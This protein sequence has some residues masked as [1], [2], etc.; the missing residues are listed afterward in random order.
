M[1]SDSKRE[2]DRNG[3]RPKQAAEQPGLALVRHELRVPIDHILSYCESLQEDVSTPGACRDELRRIHAAARRLLGLIAEHFDEES[4]ALQKPDF[5]QIGHDLR[6]PVNHIV[7]YAEMLVEEAEN[8]G[9]PGVVPNLRRIA[10][11]ARQWL[12]LMERHLLSLKDQCR[13][14]REGEQGTTEDSSAGA[15]GF[16][17]PSEKRLTGRVLV[18]DDDPANRQMLAR[19][20]R[21]QGLTVSVA[22]SGEA[23]LEKARQS[24]YDLILLDM[25]MP[26]MDGDEVLARLKSDPALAPIPVIMISALDQ[27]DRIA[28]CV[29]MGAEDYIAKPFN[30]VFLRARIKACLEQKRLREQETSF[31]RRI[32]EEK[33]KTDELLHVILPHEVAEELRSTS[34]VRPKRFSKVAVLF[35][36]IVGFAAYSCGKTPEEIVVHLQTLVESFENIAER[37]GLEKIKTIGDCFMAVAGLCS[38]SSNPAIDAVRCGLEMIGA[39]RAHP[40]GWQVRV[41]VNVGPVVAGVVGRKK[42]QYDVWGDTVNLAARLEQAGE[43]GAVCVSAALW[44]ELAEHF[45]GYC[46]GRFLIKGHGELELY[47]VPACKSDRPTNLSAAQPQPNDLGEVK[48]FVPR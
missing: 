34:T 28:R 35:C 22:S 37:H 15:V 5:R 32:Q 33:R 47:V 8:I 43:P 19:R 29:E 46:K 1:N 16:E 45:D 6:T 17:K 14:S 11:E 39:V 13:Y 12:A 41:G 10:S 31:L 4:I 20:L 3:S 38:P 48:A 26:G 30:P 21:R 25:V 44:P 42:Y 9:C 24:S 36:D 27:E 40:A 7:G 18:V 2:N 23:A